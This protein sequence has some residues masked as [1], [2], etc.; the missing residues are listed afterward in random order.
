LA[1]AMTEKYGPTVRFQL[2]CQKREGL[3]NLS[4]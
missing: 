2:R 4:I 3:W 1:A